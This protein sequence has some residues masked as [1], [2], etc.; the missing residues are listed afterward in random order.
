MAA[1]FARPW[2]GLPFL[3][4][5]MVLEHVCRAIIFVFFSLTRP[6]YSLLSGTWWF[7]AQA[8]IATNAAARESIGRTAAERVS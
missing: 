5:R 3:F 1:L 4:V 2:M 8:L 7:V 6:K